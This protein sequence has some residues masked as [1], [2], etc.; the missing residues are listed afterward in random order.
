[1]TTLATSVFLPALRRP[2]ARHWV[3]VW[4]HGRVEDRSPLSQSWLQS[5]ALIEDDVV[6]RGG[7][8]DRQRQAGAGGEDAE[9]RAEID[10][11]P[12]RD[13]MGRQPLSLALPLVGRGLGGRAGRGPRGGPGIDRGPTAGRARRSTSRR[14]GTIAGCPPAR[15]AGEVGVGRGRR[16]LEASHRPRSMKSRASPGRDRIASSYRDRAGSNWPRRRSGGPHPGPGSGPRPGPSLAPAVATPP[17]GRSV[18]PRGAGERVRPTFARASESRSQVARAPLPVYWPNWMPRIARCPFGSIVAERTRQSGSFA[19]RTSRRRRGPRG[20]PGRR[21]SSRQRAGRRRR[22]RGSRSW[23]ANGFLRPPAPAD[24][25]SGGPP[26]ST[27]PTTID[28]SLAPARNVFPSVVKATLKTNGGTRRGGSRGRRR[29]R[30]GEARGRRRRRGSSAVGRD[31]DGQDPALV[32][33]DGPDQPAGAEVPDAGLA[34]VAPADG[35]EAVGEEGDGRTE[36]GCQS[37]RISRPSR[38]VPDAGRGR[39]RS[40]R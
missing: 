38:R 3:Q 6:R 40:R 39:W 9:R 14:R 16:A 19:R 22:R 18:R 26:P 23:P 34:V 27:L 33:G 28:P 15:R 36:L 20:S 30:R 4:R 17:P 12:A 31:G 32:H 37:R 13:G 8:D 7:F 21:C 11:A 29:R 25:T 24:R 2:S 5:S 35:A 1:M 10:D